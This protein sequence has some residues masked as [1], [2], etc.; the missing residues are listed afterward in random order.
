LDCIWEGGGE[1]AELAGLA[2]LAA[3]LVR[4]RDEG[5]G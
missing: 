2:G 3:G 1:A 5:M 4:R